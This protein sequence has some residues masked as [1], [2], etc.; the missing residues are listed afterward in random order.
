MDL[1]ETHQQEYQRQAHGNESAQATRQ[2]NDP[3]SDLMS[4]RARRVQAQME[5]DTPFYSAPFPPNANFFLDASKDD[6]DRSKDSHGPGIEKPTCSINLLCRRNGILQKHQI[7]VI[8][9]AR[10]SSPDQSENLI[11][12]NKKLI[13]TD[14]QLFEVVRKT[15]QKKMYGIW[16]RIFSLKTLR[17]IRLVLV[18]FAVY[19]M[20]FYHV[21]RL[22]VH[23]F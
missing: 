2:T 5:D 13:Q 12:S 3:P 8:S 7:Q 21:D 15:Y 9:Q 14:A 23:P 17:E 16:R 4:R 20:D 22:I 18:S 6:P 19:Y 11:A 10:C 1:D